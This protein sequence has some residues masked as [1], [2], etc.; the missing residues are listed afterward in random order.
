MIKFRLMHISDKMIHEG[1]VEWVGFPG[2]LGDFEVGQDHIPMVSLLARGRVTIKL[3]TKSAETEYK[4]V[5]IEQG[6]VRFDGKELYAMV[7]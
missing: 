7:E 1:D 5:L 3:P 6:I 2:V 4:R